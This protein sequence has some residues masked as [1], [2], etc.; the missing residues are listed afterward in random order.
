MVKECHIVLGMD[1]SC[2]GGMPGI[3]ELSDSIVAFVNDGGVIVHF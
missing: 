1:K 2:F 3:Y